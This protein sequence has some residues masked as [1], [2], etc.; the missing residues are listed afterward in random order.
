MKTI[1]RIKNYK[2]VSEEIQIQN[3]DK[4][5]YLVGKNSSGKS[6]ILNA[7]SHLN[8]GSNSRRFFNETSVV[9]FTIDDLK[10]T[11]IWES[12]DKNPNHTSHVGSLKL[13]I[14][15]PDE[16][17]SD[18][19]ANGVQKR[20]FN[21]DS[22]N[23]KSLEYLNETSEI[24]G[25]SPISAQRIINNDDPWDET[26]GNRIFL[27]K[28]KEILL[29]HLA[30]GLKSF[31]NL[32]YSITKPFD[33]LK[34]SKIEQAHSILIILEE[35]ENNL[36]PD[37]QKMIPKLL[38]DFLINLKTEVSSKIHFFVSTHSPFIV[39]ASS[40]Y[41]DHKVYMLKEGNV[42]D[43]SLDIVK[44]SSGYSGFECA[45]IVGQM[46]GAN[47]TDLGYPENY[48]ILEEY[49]LQLILQDFQQK[50]IIKNFQFVSASGISR[51]ISFSKTMNE[52]ENL[53]TLVKCNPYYTDKYCLIIDSTNDLSPKEKARFTKIKQKLDDR[54]V[55]LSKHSL[56]DY[57]EQFNADVFKEYTEEIS[58][59]KGREKGLIK[60]K[61]AGKIATLITSKEEFSSLFNNELDFL[62]MA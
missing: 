38:D 12:K 13:I 1:L 21:Y 33:D 7:I 32:R 59:V 2:R 10:Q 22:I 56:E 27:Q 41:E 15:I 49:S 5:N 24:I 46:L 6:S 34:S 17:N 51:T 31:N 52:I 45:W 20:K 54:F 42:V 9:E 62:L 53:N 37:L 35:P 39:G 47:V 14:I 28:R 16:D 25:I 55:E 61:Y 30:D 8:D 60:V 44:N 58:A 23:K 29:A 19:G 48:C 11:I 43:L 4:V 57:Y 40:D 3:F 26:V 18:K 50:G 36:H